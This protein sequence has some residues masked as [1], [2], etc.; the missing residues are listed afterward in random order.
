MIT[1]GQGVRI[2]AYGRIPGHRDALFKQKAA[3]IQRFS[4]IIISRANSQYGGIFIDA[5]SSHDQLDALLSH[6]REGAVDTI[7][8]ASMNTLSLRREELYRTLSEL[9][10][11]GVDV[12]FLDEGLNTSGEGGEELLSTLAS[13]LKPPKIKKTDPAPYG[14]GDEEEAAVVQRIFSL[15]LEGYGRTPIAAMLNAD[16]VPPPITDIKKDCAAWTYCD[17]RRILADPVYRDEGLI[18]EQTWKHTQAEASRRNGA[19]GRRPP[20][21][22]P[23]RGLIT[24]GV[25]GDHFTRRERGKSSLWLCKTY[26]RGS[27]ASC[28]SRCIREDKLF[29]IINEAVSG[30]G[31]VDNITVWPDGHLIINTPT[32]D[33]EKNWEGDAK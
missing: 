3:M 18:D 8:T 17:I 2:A 30:V 6:S 23:L 22:S 21:A 4:E 14:I 28:P 31:D 10:D 16:H 5:G 20:A 15:F 1:E 25:C 9:K 7:I 29:S 33:F 24:C 11:L 13:F 27:R 26:L 19:Y 32:G 12:D